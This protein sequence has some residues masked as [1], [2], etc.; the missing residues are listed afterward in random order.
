MIYKVVWSLML[1]MSAFCVSAEEKKC[2][3]TD[4]IGDSGLVRE[5]AKS[6]ADLEWLTHAKVC[7]LGPYQVAVPE[8]KPDNSENTPVLLLKDGKPLFQRS[9]T[10]TMLFDPNTKGSKLTPLVNMWHQKDYKVERLFTD[11]VPNVNG[12]Y[13]TLEDINYDGQPDRKI[14]RK[15]HEVSAF[16]IWYQG[17]WHPMQRT[18]MPLG[19]RCV[20]MEFI[21]GKWRQKK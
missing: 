2:S 11:T 15:G 16:F 21:D 7:D 5:Y 20:A 8:G 14:M 4:L 1:M 12:E 19:K 6:D 10:D 17:Q 18:C 13:T 3:V 9:S